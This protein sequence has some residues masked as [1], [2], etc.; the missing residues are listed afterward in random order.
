MRI[1]IEKFARAERDV[2]RGQV[3]APCLRG[4]KIRVRVQGLVSTFETDPKDFEGWGVF[5]FNKA[6]VAVLKESATDL[7]VRRY[8]S[9]FA[10]VRVHLVQPL[11]GKSWLAYPVNSDVAGR[12]LGFHGPVVVHLV[13]L[14]RSFQ[15]AVCRW[16]GSNLWFERIDRRADPTVAGHVATALR[17]FVAPDKLVF[18]GCTKEVRAAYG[19]LFKHSEEAQNHRRVQSDEHR[20]ASALKQGGGELDSFVDRGDC[21]TVQWRTGSGER[22]S[23]AITKSDL[24]VMSAGICLDGEDELFDLQSLVGV[25]EQAD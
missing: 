19:L 14:A 11:G 2:R 13:G 7:Q 1:L 3:L 17:N 18:S 4:G 9:L 16:D 23:S 21:W 5:G 25:V 10:N 8:L 12:V 22:H 15:Q 24:T 6:G 20:L